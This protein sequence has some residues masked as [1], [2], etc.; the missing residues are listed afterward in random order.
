[1]NI[2]TTSIENRTIIT[3][4]S[5]EIIKPEQLKKEWNFEAIVSLVLS[6]LAMITTWILFGIYGELFFV[7]IGLILAIA[8]CLFGFTAISE[9]NQSHESKGLGIAILGIILGIV[10]GLFSILGI[11]FYHV[12]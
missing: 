11:L 12:M 9:I 1:M 4:A 6:L 7:V 10:F 5:S 3:M 8:A 2:N